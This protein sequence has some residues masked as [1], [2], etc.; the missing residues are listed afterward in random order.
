MLY[1]RLGLYPLFE[2]KR[3]N[4]EKPKK[5]YLH[6]CSDYTSKYKKVNCEQT[7]MIYSQNRVTQKRYII[8]VNTPKNVKGASRFLA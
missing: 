4:L 2:S 6:Q 8:A 3:V 5:N 1:T 7:S